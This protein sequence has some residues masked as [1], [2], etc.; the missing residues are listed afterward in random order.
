MKVSLDKGKTFKSIT[1]ESIDDAE[2]NLTSFALQKILV[3]LKYSLEGY[4]LENLLGWKNVISYSRTCG[5]LHENLYQLPFPDQLM[6]NVHKIAL[7]T[8]VIF[9]SRP[10]LLDV[11]LCSSV[12]VTIS[13]QICFFLFNT[14]YVRM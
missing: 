12:L 2:D 13:F 8:A 1:D 5:F 14:L 4:V 11:Y 10:S 9:T 3:E 6:T 7:K